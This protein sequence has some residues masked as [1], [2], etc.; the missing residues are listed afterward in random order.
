MRAFVAIDLPDEI[1][2]A[3]AREQARLKAAC[4]HHRHVRWT[5]PEGLHLTLRFLGEIEQAQAA[6]AIAAFQGLGRF[7]PF[8]VEVK[9]FG[10][11]PDPRRPRV[12]WVGLQAPASLTELAARVEAAL[13][14]LG[15][16]GE[17]RPFKPHLTLAR[18]DRPQSPA[19]LAE[20]TEGS[21]VRSFGQFEVS[22]F[23]LFESRLRLGGAEYFKLAR[24]PAPQSA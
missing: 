16:P 5:R 9:G 12:F 6:S 20:A 19:A 3:L 15:F 21:S 24:F 13:E 18:F 1:R 23:F 17:H 10:F 2:A 8:K 22:E 4:A 7:D 14:P 11:F